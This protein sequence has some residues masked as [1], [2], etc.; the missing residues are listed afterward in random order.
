[1][2]YARKKGIPVDEIERDD[3]HTRWLS[4]TTPRSATA[5]VERTSSRTK[6]DQIKGAM[7]LDA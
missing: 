4:A 2:W 5:G 3:S 6:T 1:M 7:F